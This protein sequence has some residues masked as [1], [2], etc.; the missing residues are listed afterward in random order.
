MP[1]TN[2]QSVLIIENDDTVLENLSNR[3]K[4]RDMLVITAKDGYEGYTRACKESPDLIV[5]ETLLPSMNGFR[6]SRLLK[7]DERY[8][9]IPV[10]LITSN[11]LDTVQD[12]FRAS[13][14]D[15]ILGKPFRFRDLMEKITDLVAV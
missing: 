8:R 5:S 1:D 3:F 6:V 11:N 7:F 2:K 14:A 15:Q 13:G 4:K 10:V 9:N 12:M